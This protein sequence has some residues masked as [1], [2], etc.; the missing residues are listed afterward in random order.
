MTHPRSVDATDA[1]L[2]MALN[3][4]PRATTLALA[5]RAHLSRNTVQSRVARLEKGHVLRSFERRV[6]PAALGYPVRAF[7][8]TNLRQR[9]LDAVGAALALIPEVVEV[10]GLSGVADLLIQVVARHV[11]DLYR[12]A[13]EILAIDG[14]ERTTTGLVM[15]EMVDFRVSPLLEE[16]AGD[17]T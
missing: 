9:E 5:E 14:V 15:R 12:I 17:A 4:E 3:A 2:L 1:R 10:H 11:E 16:L 8:M 7:I 6:D 13:G